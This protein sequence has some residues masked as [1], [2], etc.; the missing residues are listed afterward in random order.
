MKHSKL[1]KDL[2]PNAKNPRKIS[3][4]VQA[5]LKLALKKFGDLGCIVF[6]VTTGNLVGGHQR[7][8]SLHANSKVFIEKEY[9]T[10]NDSRTV[11]EG[12]VESNGEHFKYRE[13]EADETWEAEAMLAANKFSGEWD[14]PKVKALI[15]S[16]P[17]IDLRMTGF[18]VPELDVMGIRVN[19]P[20]IP[21]N[22]EA[23]DAKHIAETPQ[24][25]E[26]IPTSPASAGGTSF[27]AI[28]EN[29]EPAGR[30][31]VLIIDCDGDDERKKALKVQLQPLV[32]KAGAKFF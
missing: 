23:D 29:T 4:Q 24:T 15:Q 6:N 25:T 5:D 11:R 26:Q 3:S 1:L 28:N 12:Y 17:N 2:K 20:T 14:T 27:D 21:R 13:V 16:V 10:P 32:E 8:K 31:V 22:D 19:L 18:K 7:A 30:R 9:P